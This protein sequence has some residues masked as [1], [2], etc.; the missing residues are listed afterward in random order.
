MIQKRKIKNFPLHSVQSFKS[1]KKAIRF[2]KAPVSLDTHLTVLDALLSSTEL[3][4]MPS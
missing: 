4:L 1:C 3:V 2:I